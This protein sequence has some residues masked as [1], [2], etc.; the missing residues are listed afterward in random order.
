MARLSASVM[1]TALVAMLVVATCAVA[2]VSAGSYL[3]TNWI[4]GRA[5]ATYYGGV[6]ASG[7]QGRDRYID[8]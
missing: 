7:T 5:H 4:G 8:M 2:P 6:D 1:A 3:G